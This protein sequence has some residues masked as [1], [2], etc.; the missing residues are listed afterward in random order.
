[1]NTAP[2]PQLLAHADFGAAEAGPLHG[3]VRQFLRETIEE[4]F[5]DG[6]SFWTERLLIERLGI[7]RGTL[8]QALDELA[9]E[10]VLV[11]EAKRGSFVRKTTVMALG[12]I[13]ERADT[14]FY[15]EMTQH[16]AA[17][18]IAR[19]LR[20]ELYPL[21]TGAS[22]EKLP[23]EIRH[24]PTHERLLLMPEGL[25][26]AANLPAL[27]SE[28]GYRVLSLDDVAG[29]SGVPFVT[30]DGEK[31]VRMAFDHLQQIGHRRIAFLVNEP[32][33]RPSVRRKMAEFQRLTIERDLP[34]ALLADCETQFGQSSF[35]KA[36]AMMPT[37]WDD[38]VRR[39]TAIFTASD[40]GA[41]AAL[42]WFAEQN[43][44]VP[45]EVSVLGYEGV[46]PDAFT[47]PPLSTIAHDFDELAR[48]A[49]DALW[50]SGG[51]LESEWVA[52]R[53]VL[54]QSTAPPL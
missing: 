35:E 15:A 38:E 10:G 49:V 29:Q 28:R 26:G 24:Q 41:W 17:Q 2:S 9:R 43:I 13:F 18:C 14:D 54:R 51:A 12:L 1:M 5:E 11:R 20:L 32:S 6:Q 45:D 21:L 23:D 52:P 50:I 19:G 30:T 7:A 48:R 27:L 44:K 4:H 37:L 34:E 53:L 16:L 25:S 47:H 8:R 40:P 31:A 22:A 3:Q 39:P 36:Y 46:K 33:E 42:R